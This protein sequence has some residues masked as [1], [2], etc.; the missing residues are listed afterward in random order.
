MRWARND[1]LFSIRRPQFHLNEDEV[2][3]L[4]AALDDSG[5]GVIDFDEMVAHVRRHLLE[6]QA[7]CPS[8]FSVL[9]SPNVTL[10]DRVTTRPHFVPG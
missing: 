2:L 10:S 1:F 9:G 3:T 7:A 6:Q 4:I 5:D 8:S